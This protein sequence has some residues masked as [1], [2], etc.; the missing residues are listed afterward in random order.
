MEDVNTTLVDTR[1]PDTLPTL[2]AWATALLTLFPDARRLHLGHDEAAWQSDR[3]FEDEQNP[4]TAGTHRALI[5]G[6]MA[7][8][9]T[10][11]EGLLEG[12]DILAT[13]RAAAACGALVERLGDGRVRG[14]GQGGLKAQ[15]GRTG[16]GNAR[17]R[18]APVM[19]LGAA[20]GS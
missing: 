10:E 1:H 5:F 8:G 4:R 14:G 6:A 3:W 19:V 7:T 20:Y 17:T 15:A 11:I 12:D 2:Q 18:G 16:C 9:V 13:G